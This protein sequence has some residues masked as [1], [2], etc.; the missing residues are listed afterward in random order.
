MLVLLKYSVL[1]IEEV[2]VLLQKL[3]TSAKEL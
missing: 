1:L 3:I 2:I